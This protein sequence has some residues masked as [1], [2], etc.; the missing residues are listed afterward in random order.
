MSHPGNKL[1]NLYI[2]IKINLLMRNQEQVTRLNHYTSYQ[3]MYR[4]C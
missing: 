2:Y 4:T 1:H 3:D